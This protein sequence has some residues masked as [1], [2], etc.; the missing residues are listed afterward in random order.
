[1]AK[2]EFI[3]NTDCLGYM[4]ILY[5]VCRHYNSEVRVS[6]VYSLLERTLGTQWDSRLKITSEEDIRDR[7]VSRKLFV[8]CQLIG[9]IVQPLIG[10]KWVVLK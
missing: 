3:E 1:M 4:G 2:L 10:G 5:V 7:R 6:E 8:D 9:T